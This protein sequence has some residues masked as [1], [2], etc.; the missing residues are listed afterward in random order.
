MAV[1]S[2]YPLPADVVELVQPYQ[3]NPKLAMLDWCATTVL[4]APILPSPGKITH[5]INEITGVR[6]EQYSLSTWD[7]SKGFNGSEN[8][9][10]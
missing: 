8:L 6:P 3:F 5:A 7:G 1:V 4:P 2:L 10:L 9:H